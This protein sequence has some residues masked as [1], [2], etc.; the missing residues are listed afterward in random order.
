MTDFKSVYRDLCDEVDDI[1]IFSQAWWLDVVAG[2]ENWNVAIVR[3]DNKVIASMPYVIQ[4]KFGMTLLRQPS[5]TQTLGPWIKKSDAKYAKS[6]SQQKDLMESLIDQLPAY[7][8]F[9]QNWHYSQTNWLPFFWKGFKQTTRYTY[10]IND[11]TDERALWEELQQNI[12]TDIKK[13]ESRFLITV[14]EDSS[15]DEFLELNKLVFKRQNIGLPYSET[16]V[17]KIDQ[18]CA[19]RGCRKIFIAVDEQGRRHAGIYLIWDSNSAYYLM[20]GGDPE[21]RNSGATSLCMWKA[22][23]FSSSVTKAFDFE[24]SMMEPVERFFRGFGAHQTPYFSISKVKSKV[25]DTA[26][27]IRGLKSW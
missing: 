4:K 24:G 1:P 21:L 17:R 22:I 10:V 20:G 11:L 19:E 2:E 9:T 16:L 23:R 6:L 12:R 14:K 26:F 5:L 25:I 3:R 13:A 18:A 7:Q 8:Y 27:F 15:I